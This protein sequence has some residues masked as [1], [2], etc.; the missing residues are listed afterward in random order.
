M[1][2]C[3]QL[4]FCTTITVYLLGSWFHSAHT[5][6]CTFTLNWL[7]PCDVM[8]SGMMLERF[9][10]SRKCWCFDIA[11]H[12]VRPFPGTTLCHVSVSEGCES[13]LVGH[14]YSTLINTQTLICN[15][16]SPLSGNNNSL[17]AMCDGRNSRMNWG[18]TLLST[19]TKPIKG[20]STDCAC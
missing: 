7:A 18:F 6:N 20:D 8:Y 2:Y 17:T 14:L 3:A 19:L 4:S 16:S 13:T 11:R 9:K 1:S 12:V 5:E 15:Y 10:V